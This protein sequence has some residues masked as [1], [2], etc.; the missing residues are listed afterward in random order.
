M[1]FQKSLFMIILISK[2]NTSSK[3][4]GEEALA[5]SLVAMKLYKRM[6]QEAEDDDVNQEEIQILRNSAEVFKQKSL[7][8]LKLG[9]KESDKMCYQLLTYELKSW[10]RHTCL[11]LAVLAQ[12]RDLI[13]HPCVQNIISDLWMG[14][15]DLRRNSN[16][17]VSSSL[18]L[19]PFL[20]PLQLLPHHYNHS[21]IK[22]KTHEQLL[23]QP[24]T[25]QEYL[26]E[27]EVRDI[28]SI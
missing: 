21:F 8:L 25:M 11:S 5:K 15:M 16:L 13:A 20:A 14:G 3:S 28:L 9:Y 23:Q 6:A 10:S 24:Q 1:S 7:E 19:F 4:Q 17:K 27:C 26:D 18:W 2:N 22:F 12:H